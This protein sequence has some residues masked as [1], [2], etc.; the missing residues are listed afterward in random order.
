MRLS[1]KLT[2]IQT[3]FHTK[4]GPVILNRNE[5][6]DITEDQQKELMDQPLFKSYVD[7]KVIEVLGKVNDSVS[8]SPDKAIEPNDVGAATSATTKAKSTKTDS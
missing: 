8:T 6:A 1:H 3:T 2:S 4:D 7:S 5:T